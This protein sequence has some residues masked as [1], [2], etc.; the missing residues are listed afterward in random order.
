MKDVFLTFSV[1]YLTTEMSCVLLNS[2]EMAWHF[3]DM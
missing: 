1:S 2:Y 3:L